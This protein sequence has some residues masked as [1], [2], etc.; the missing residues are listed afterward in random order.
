MLVCCFTIYSEFL[1]AYFKGLQLLHKYVSVITGDER[2][3]V[4][5][6]LESILDLPTHPSTIFV[7]SEMEST[8]VFF[9]TMWTIFILYG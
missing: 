6:E 7:I 5:L 3:D 9:G 4:D 1:Y 2:R 8:L